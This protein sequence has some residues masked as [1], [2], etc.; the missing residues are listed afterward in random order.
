MF[1]FCNHKMKAYAKLRYTQHDVSM[2][3]TV[4]LMTFKLMYVSNIIHTIVLNLVSLED[5]ATL[6]GTS[7]DT[8]TGKCTSARYK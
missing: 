1:L 8:S 5:H 3:T 2:H 6:T 4:C 7:V